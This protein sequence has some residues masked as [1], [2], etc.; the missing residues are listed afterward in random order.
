MYNWYIFPY[1]F[2]TAIN[3]FMYQPVNVAVVDCGIEYQEPSKFNRIIILDKFGISMTI[4]ANYRAMAKDN[5]TVEILDGGTYDAFVCHAQNPGATGGS[6][7]YSIEIYKS[8]AS[9]LYENVWDKVPGKENMY[10]VWEKTYAGQELNYHYIKLRIKTK[11]GLVEI[12]AGSEHS[13]QTEDDVKAALQD[14]LEIAQN[15]EILE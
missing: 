13:T 10:I 9:Y 14:I 15:T 11:K 12:D 1:L 4:P 8:K 5:G 3:L 2:I 6:G 7:Y